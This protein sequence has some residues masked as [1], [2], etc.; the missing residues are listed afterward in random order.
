MDKF[1]ILFIVFCAWV[2][3][4]F[5][6]SYIYLYRKLIRPTKGKTPEEAVRYLKSLHWDKGKDLTGF[7]EKLFRRTKYFR[8]LKIII[9][10]SIIFP[11]TR[12]A[13]LGY[14]DMSG[15]S[16]PFS[17][18]AIW[19]FVLLPILSA[20]PY[21]IILDKASRPYGEFLKTHRG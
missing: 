19:I 12:L 7:A 4:A 17:M 14:L 11:I 6:I 3:I 1:D 10:V 13:L 18:Y 5:P 21:F 20:I 16:V 2:I 15:T 9:P 8:Y